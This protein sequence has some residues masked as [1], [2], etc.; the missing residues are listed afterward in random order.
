[1]S[2]FIYTD[3]I[4]GLLDPRLVWSWIK[5]DPRLCI[6]PQDFSKEIFLQL[7][8]S[9]LQWLMELFRRRFIIL[10][11]MIFPFVIILA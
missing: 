4:S 10:N 9:S 3:L 11:V 8:Y 6:W 2:Y 5:I 7:S 1:M